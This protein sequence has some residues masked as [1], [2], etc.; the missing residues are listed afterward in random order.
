MILLV[1]LLA[2]VGCRTMAR[3]LFLPFALLAVLFGGLAS[4]F[5]SAD[6]AGDDAELYAGGVRIIERVLE[7]EVDEDLTFEGS[8]R[9]VSTVT[10]PAGIELAQQVSLS[11]DPRSQELELVSAKVVNPDGSVH[12]VASDQVFER[13]T[14]L[15]QG[16]PEYLS[17]LT[18]SVLLPQL[19]VGSQVHMEWHFTDAAVPVLGFNYTWRPSFAIPVDESRIKI[20]YHEDAP[21]RFDA[22]APFVLEESARG[23]KRTVTATL[24]DYEA[25]TPE[26]AMVAP[27][28]VC[29]E[30]VVTTT[31]SWEEIGA[32]FH[33]VMQE[34]IEVTPEVQAL[35]AEIVG[36]EEGLDAARAIHRWVCENINYV[37][38]YMNASDGW[39]PHH[40]SEVLEHGY[41]DCKDKVVLTASL[42][43]ARGIQAEPALV[44]LDRGFQ[45]FALPTPMQFNHCMVYLPELGLYSNPTD[46]YR[47]LGELGPTLSG[48][49]VV[50]ATEAGRVTRTPESSADDNAYDV[51][52]K[53]AIGADGVVTGRSALAFRGRS[54]GQ[55]RRALALSTDTNEVADTL[56]HTGLL[57]GHGELQTTDPTDLETPLRCEGEWTSDIPIAMGPSI[58]FMTPTGIDP[59]NVH[60]VSDFVSTKERRYPVLISAIE[61]AWHYELELPTGFR[62]DAVPG[63]REKETAAGR[64]ESRY[65]LTE[66]GR[67]LV[68]RRLRIE[69]DLYA[70]EQY[71]A[72]RA[73][74]LES[75]IDR[76][77][78]LS[79][80]IES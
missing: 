5:V 6:G 4:I 78:I 28:D 20:T 68:D 51:E 41:G 1:S 10:E 67:L 60:V 63:G 18:K 62:F 17:S 21:L 31:K 71:D 55:F 25:Q 74:L 57:G 80:S 73:I 22:Q 29:P 38:V 69:R 46:P 19:T 65:Q 52:H 14:A 45:P 77:T 12:E 54:E 32:A 34:R 43:A 39:I 61:L 50:L 56:L 16:A 3:I 48:K 7:V 27:R 24:R 33:A 26:R 42:L 30:F 58:H 72:L 13:P 64:F 23:K 75:I 53:V 44:R 11:Y 2:L 76:E 59:V 36:D 9:V 15:T 40:V 47:D 35:A 37:V 79:A 49:F 70:S 66:D 8:L